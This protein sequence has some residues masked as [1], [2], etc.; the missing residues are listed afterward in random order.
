MLETGDMIGAGSSMYRHAGAASA[1]V[2]VAFLCV[3]LAR[4]S[5]GTQ[6]GDT[7]GTPRFRL[8]RSVSGSVGQESGG[9]FV[10]ED[11][12]TVFQI[13]GDKQVIVSFEWQGPPGQ[14]HIECSWKDPSGKVVITASLD[15]RA[16]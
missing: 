7:Q 2:G 1:F 16:P 9:R 14:H 12:R 8:L 4:V 13:P 5:E 11:P 6:S 3:A 15:Q 10:I